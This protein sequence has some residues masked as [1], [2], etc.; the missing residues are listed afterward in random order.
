M[1]ALDRVMRI[2]AAVLA[3]GYVSLMMMGGGVYWIIYVIGA[4]AGQDEHV[5]RGCILIGL[6]LIG[7]FIGSVV[8]LRVWKFRRD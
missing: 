6:S 8:G 2:V 7:L 4:G 5:L 1:I 3:G